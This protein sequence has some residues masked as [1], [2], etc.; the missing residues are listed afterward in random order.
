MFPSDVTGELTPLQLKL[1]HRLFKHSRSV[2]YSRNVPSRWVVVVHANQLEVAGIDI[3]GALEPEPDFLLTLSYDFTNAADFM[4]RMI[5]L[6]IQ[7]QVS[8]V[9]K[10]MN[11]D[12]KQ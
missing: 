5:S 11:G 2:G 8:Y 6:E 9:S 12:V 4:A 7:F 1:L 3:W 10:S